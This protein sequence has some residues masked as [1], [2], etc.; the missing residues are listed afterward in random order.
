MDILKAF[1]K[2]WHEGLELKL[3]SNGVSGH[4]L[5]LFSDLLDE[6]YQRTVLNGKSSD[7]KRITAGVPQG[8]VLGPLLFLIY[9]NGLADNSVQCRF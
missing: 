5:N 6:R 3:K 7:W 2:M 8:S 4:L 1:D 9:I